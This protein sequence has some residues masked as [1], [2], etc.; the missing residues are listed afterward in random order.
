MSNGAP[1]TAISYSPTVLMSS[2]YGAFKNVLIPAK[3]GWPPRTKVVIRRSWTDG[4]ASSPSS[5]AR[6]AV[7]C[8]RSSPTWLSWSSMH[9]ACRSR[10]SKGD[11]SGEL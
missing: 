4:A 6:R 1:T 5:S 3:A 8:S 10:L 7:S 9:V 11:L 2:Q